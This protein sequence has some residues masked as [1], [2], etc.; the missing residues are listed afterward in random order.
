VTQPEDQGHLLPQDVWERVQ[1]DAE[2]QAERIAAGH[3]PHE[4]PVLEEGRRTTGVAIPLSGVV[5]ADS[6]GGRRSGPPTFGVLH[7]AETPL[8]A[9]YAGSLSRNWFGP[10]GGATTSCHYFTDPA[11][12]WGVLPDELVAYHVGGANPRSIGVEQAGY[13]RYTRAEWTTPEGMAQLRRNAVLMRAMRDRYGIGLFWNTD[14]QLRDA[15]AGRY[16]AGWSTHEQCRRVI[17]GTTHTDPGT[18]FPHDLQMQLAQE[19]DEDMPLTEKDAQLVARELLDTPLPV[20]FQDR[21]GAWQTA[22]TVGATLQHLVWTLTPGSDG[23]RHAGHV[24]R[25][26]SAISG[27]LATILQRTQIA[28]PAVTDLRRAAATDWEPEPG[29]DDRQA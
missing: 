21:H 5:H 23:V 24:N 4:A 22:P 7:S 10:S 11:E 25:A 12:T 15:H 1:A 13:A 16:V 17:G 2:R 14:Q 6:H 29:Q 18:G 27:G 28:A 19:E 3:A 8:R 9:G 20:T 26:L